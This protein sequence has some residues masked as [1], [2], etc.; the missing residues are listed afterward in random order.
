MQSKELQKR[1]QIRSASSEDRQAGLETI[2]ERRAKESEHQVQLSLE[3]NHS[4]QTK[5]R[6]TS[7]QLER[8]RQYMREWYKRA[9]STE[10]PERRERKQQ[11]DRLNK[12]QARQ[13]KTPEQRERRLER[14]RVGKKRVIETETSEEREKGWKVRVY[15][16]S[17]L[18]Q[19][20]H[21]K[22]GKKD[23]NETV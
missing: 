23:S 14:M 16:K 7:E 22:N 17:E 8:K 15:G 5:Q 9:K 12:R 10:T 1:Q 6:M 21:Q 19:L 13:R 3:R 4:C 18:E 11:E 2:G 20:K